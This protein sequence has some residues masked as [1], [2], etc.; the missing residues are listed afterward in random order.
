MAPYAAHIMKKQGVN[1]Q[2]N[3][4]KRKT[5]KNENVR[6]VR[7]DYVPEERILAHGCAAPVPKVLCTTRLSRKLPLDGALHLTN[8]V[9]VAN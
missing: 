8:R 2:G 3:N 4:M 5:Q 9:L 6:N 1:N 7:F